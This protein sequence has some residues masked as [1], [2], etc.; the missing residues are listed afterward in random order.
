VTTPNEHRLT[1]PGFVQDLLGRA[2]SAGRY[3]RIPAVQLAEADPDQLADILR[4]NEDAALGLRRIVEAISGWPG[5]TSV[6]EAGSAAA[7]NIALHA[8]HDPHFQHTLL[9]KLQRAARRGEATTAQWAHLFDRY[10][11]NAGGWQTYGTQHIYGPRGLQPY[12]IADPDGLDTRR[13]SV[14]LPLY[15]EQVERLRRHHV[16]DTALHT[17]SVSPPDRRAVNPVRT[18]LGNRPA[19]P[20]LTA[21]GGTR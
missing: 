19:E 1:W 3:W 9:I 16:G 14:G 21:S 4:M 8:D 6:G 15:R 10:Q 20:V 5:I 11:A 7:L 2:E 13:A 12:P 17:A 18:P